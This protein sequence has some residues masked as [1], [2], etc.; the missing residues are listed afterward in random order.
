MSLQRYVGHIRHLRDRLWMPG[1]HGRAAVLVGAGFSRNAQAIY[2]DAPEFA[3][4]S[5]YVEVFAKALG[6]DVNDAKFIPIDRLAEEYESSFGREALN[7]VIQRLIPW[8]AYRPGQL[9]K[10]LLQLPWADIF[11]TNYDPLLESA[12]QLVPTRRYDFVTH[13]DDLPTAQR[14]RIIKL[15]G[16]FP[17]TRPFVFTEEDFRQYPQRFAP[18]VNAVQQSMLENTLCLVGF[19][20]DDPNFLRWAGWIRDELGPHRPLI[21]LVNILNLNDARRRYLE[22]RQIIPIDLGDILEFKDGTPMSERFRIANDW[23][24]ESLKNGR[25]ENLLDWPKHS[26]PAKTIMYSP[27]PIEPSRARIRRLLTSDNYSPDQLFLYWRERRETYPKWEVFRTVHSEYLKYDPH[28]GAYYAFKSVQELPA[29]LDILLLRELVWRYTLQHAPLEPELLQEVITRLDLYAPFDTGR[30]APENQINRTSTPSLKIPAAWAP[31]GK[32]RDL[33]WSEVRSIWIELAFAVL[34][35]HRMYLDVE[36]F[37]EWSSCL[38]QHADLSHFPEWEAQWHWEQVRLAINLLDVK[39]AETSLQVWPQNLGNPFWEIRR[40]ASLGELGHLEKARTIFTSALERLRAGH[41]PGQLNPRLMSQLAWAIRLRSFIFD[42]FDEGVPEQEEEFEDKEGLWRLGID[43]SADLRHWTTL[44][45]AKYREASRSAVKL[46]FRREFDIGQA[47]RTFSTQ[48]NDEIESDPLVGMS[49]LRFLE[50]AAYPLRIGSRVFATQDLQPALLLLSHP[51]TFH[52]AVL[53]SIRVGDSNTLNGLLSR[54]RVAALPNDQL[55]FLTQ[56]LFTSVRQTVSR[57]R[58]SNDNLRLE[59]FRLVSHILTLGIEALSRVILRAS[60]DVI[61]SALDLAIEVAETPSVQQDYRCYEAMSLFVN[62]ILDRWDKDD[63]EALVQ[64][65]A[66]FPLPQSEQ[67]TYKWP[68]PLLHQHFDRIKRT[69]NNRWVTSRTVDRL[70]NVV[71]TN[72]IGQRPFASLALFRLLKMNALSDREAKRYGD[73]LWHL[74]DKHSKLPMQTGLMD[75]ALLSIP[76]SKSVQPDVRFKEYFLSDRF[77]DVE[78][79]SSVV[80][81]QGDSA[82][83]IIKGLLNLL[84]SSEPDE[85]GSVPITWSSDEAEKLLINLQEWWFKWIEYVNVSLQQRG[86]FYSGNLEKATRSILQVVHDLILKNWSEDPKIV[87]Q[88]SDLIQKYMN[89]KGFTIPS[90][91]GDHKGITH[92]SVI[93]ALLSNNDRIMERAIWDAAKIVQAGNEGEREILRRLLVSRVIDRASPELDTVLRAITFLIEQRAQILHPDEHSLL[94][95]SLDYLA[96][97]T[98]LKSQN[99]TVLS[100]EARTARSDIRA[101]ASKLVV[102]LLQHASS[103]RFDSDLSLHPTI[104]KWRAIGQNDPLPE[105]RQPWENFM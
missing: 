69:T 19:Q 75:F 104:R 7:D 67:F 41:Q 18:F 57:V 76:T 42:G 8:T 93:N 72:P 37:K 60:T 4:L 47:T 34:A 22:K 99:L 15:H 23:F 17:S 66:D 101:A 68:T 1:V 10:K 96:N 36:A 88:F 98:E 59:Q 13:P 61:R 49:F 58:G 94:L 32:E 48:F 83:T 28:H 102:I 16:S 63:I 97:E 77:F 3:L 21:Y 38:E 84:G 100:H 6:R 51:F 65:L 95:T 5:D 43:P 40:A 50:W 81:G 73:A 46:E 9:H 78:L 2:A 54:E 62:R 24:L 31:D 71:M 56:T 12:R 87:Y 85:N 92:E 14:P 82:D 79:N 30:D 25:P 103:L 64:R 44:V 26:K 86:G 27:L 39:G 35:T 105:V 29:P 55:E 45:S 53:T 90:V 74:I 89:D 11:T 52:T 80:A 70:I 91:L 20:G 33:S